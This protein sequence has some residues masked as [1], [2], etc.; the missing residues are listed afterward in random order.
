MTSKKIYKAYIPNTEGGWAIVPEIAA[1]TQID[2]LSVQWSQDDGTSIL[3]LEESIG[4]QNGVYN[5][6]R[7]A[8][9]A[10]SIQIQSKPLKE[11]IYFDVP[12]T[13]QTPLHYKDNS[14]TGN[15]ILIRYT[16]RQ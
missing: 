2:I 4:L 1:R 11:L 15:K 14:G 13:M 6:N 9:I 7:E 10:S 12:I 8:R 16:H 5:S 3:E